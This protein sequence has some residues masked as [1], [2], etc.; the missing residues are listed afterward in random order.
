MGKLII[1]NGKQTDNPFYFKLTNTYIYSLEELCYFIYH[2]VDTITE[3]LYQV[4]FL[5]WIEQEICQPDL[6]KRLEELVQPVNRPEGQESIEKGN[7]SNLK[8]ILVTI[9]CCCDY[10]GEDEIK[11]L[12]RIM[13][14]AEKLTPFEKLK[15]K[16][17]NCLKYGQYTQAAK[18]YE[19]ILSSKEVVNLRKEEYGDLKHNLALA[20]LHM[21]GTA[22][23]AR[24][25]KEA[26]DNNHNK[27]S[28][29]QYLL[30]QM[31]GKQEE[32]KAEAEN[33]GMN[34][35]ERK[36]L[37]AEL[38][39]AYGRAK[40]SSDYNALQDLIEYKDTGRITKFYQAAE[41]LMEGYKQEF[42]LENS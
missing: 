3:E 27:E 19:I 11:Q 6:S 22:E 23:A 28:L 39:A 20:K 42:R 33:Y 31:I 5:H 36:A 12:L 1:C 32:A 4:T 7:P 30:A 15:K 26:Y 34:E 25:F 40:T 24:L 38:E 41:E 37:E 17:D 35:E 8:D 21:T 18:E 29:R 10:Y 14:Q 2:N 13:E 9:L 16:A